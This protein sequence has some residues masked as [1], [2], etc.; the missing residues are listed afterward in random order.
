MFNSAGKE[1]VDGGSK[2][3]V[4]NRDG[5]SDEMGKRLKKGRSSSVL[6]ASGVCWGTEQG[7][8]EQR[9]SHLG[10]GFTFCI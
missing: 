2:V 6:M 9:E 8:W 1:K 3:E 4:G 7:F 5:P 10:I